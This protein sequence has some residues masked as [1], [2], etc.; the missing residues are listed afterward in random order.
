MQC[1]LL[2]T[3]TTTHT[4]SPARLTWDAR[5]WGALLV[6]CGVIFLDGLDV[7]MVGMSLPSIGAD[8]GVS[9]SSL[10]WVVTGYVLGYG[11]SCCS[12]AARPT[13]SAVAASS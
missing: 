5:L 3:Q 12:V 13:C 11:G 6:V 7:S 9:L 10:Q 4:T 2:V 1:S 8:L